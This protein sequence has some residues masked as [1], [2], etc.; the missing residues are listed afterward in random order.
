MTT[1]KTTA[2]ADKIAEYIAARLAA[3]RYLIRNEPDHKCMPVWLGKATELGQAKSHFF[4]DEE[5]VDA[6]L[7]GKQQIRVYEVDD[8]AIYFVA[9]I[10]IRH[11]IQLYF[12][13]IDDT[14]CG[15][16]DNSNLE[17]AEVAEQRARHITINVDDE[18]QQ[19]AWTLAQQE[20][21]GVLG[22][23]EWP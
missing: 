11:A 10:T 19:D 1:E 22:C 13:T 4:S 18:T 21:P 17:I 23:S 2:R 9:A 5:M 6:A 3:L 14:G 15:D 20:G 12:K 7:S 16:D 8:G